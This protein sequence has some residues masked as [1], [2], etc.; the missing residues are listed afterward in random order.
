ML[1][2]IAISVCAVVSLVYDLLFDS[3]S[4]YGNMLLSDLIVLYT[5]FICDTHGIS[6]D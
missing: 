3:V 4:V 6:A 5:A 2:L 1:V